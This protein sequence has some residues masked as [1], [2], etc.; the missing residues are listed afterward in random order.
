MTL[1]NYIETLKMQTE[2]VTYDDLPVRVK[3]NRILEVLGAPYGGHLGGRDADGEWFSE[4]TDFM[5]DQ[6]DRRPALYLH[7]KTPRGTTALKP[8]LI[9]KAEL[10]R[11][12]NEGLW[13][14]VKLGEG[15]LSD[16]VWEAAQAGSARASSGAVNYLV[17]KNDDGE[18][19]TWPLAELSVFD[20]GHGRHPANEL[21]RVELKALFDSAEI[22]MPES[23]VKSGEL[24]TELVQE[25]ESDSKNI[26][27]IK[28]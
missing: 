3:G 5:L 1:T 27:Y 20:T 26:I 6:G 24:E 4:R 14:E 12:D 13:F 10:T 28:R 16:R 21:A 22:D 17:R 19:L 2:L 9:G 23:F 15:G 11:R 18:I 7:G 25:E 8:E